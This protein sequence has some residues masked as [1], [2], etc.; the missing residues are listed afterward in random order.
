MYSERYDVLLLQE[1]LLRPDD[2][3]SLP[4]FSVLRRD[5]RRGTLI[6]IRNRPGLSYLPLD[7]GSFCSE[8][9]DVQGVTISDSR[10]GGSVNII[11]VYISKATTADDWEFLH[12][13]EDMGSCIVAGDFNA[14][15]PVWCCSGMYN[16][17]GRALETSLQDLDMQMISTL[18][19]TRLAQRR[20]DADT[21]IDLCLVSPD[22]M[23]D[24]TWQP[25]SLSGSDN[26]LCEARVAAAS[27]IQSAPRRAK[28]YPKTSMERDVVTRMRIRAERTKRR[29]RQENRAD[30]VKHRPRPKWWTDDVE[31]LW[32]SKQRALR[33]WR[34]ARLNS[35]EA[36]RNAARITKN[37]TDAL[38]KRGAGSSKAECWDSFIRQTN[39]N[40]TMFWRFVSSMANSTCTSAN[41]QIEHNVQGV[42]D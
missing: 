31:S 24:V 25:G 6:A 1:T 34:T 38:F 7:C 18:V 9:R 15:S 27:I 21:T 2:E 42:E 40:C 3:F 26:L 16:P 35:S 39:Q 30:D 20:G 37:R 41:L 29:S 33:E 19:P 28:L 8:A 23:P 10:R 22:I 5:D 17:N 13:I 32:I 11:N 14:R 36:V 4:G 12:H